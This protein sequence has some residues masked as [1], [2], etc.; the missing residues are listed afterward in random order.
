VTGWTGEGGR[1]P[2]WE[3]RPYSK[4]IIGT[5]YLW[6]IVEVPSE[7]TTVGIAARAVAEVETPHFKKILI[8]PKNRDWA[9][10]PRETIG[11]MKIP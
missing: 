4:S 2:Y 11:L 9:T 7:C 1:E 3:L 6:I 10:R 5:R 8:G